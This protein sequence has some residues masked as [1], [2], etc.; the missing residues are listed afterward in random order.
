MRVMQFLLRKAKGRRRGDWAA[1]DYDVVA[2]GKVVGRI[3]REPDTR[4]RWFWGTA[5][6]TIARPEQYGYADSR[7][8]A[9]AAFRAMWE[10]R[11]PHDRRSGTV[12]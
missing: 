4:E 7:K 11:A 12:L 5:L 3:Y 8:A 2:D 6:E 1:A 10:G 9:L